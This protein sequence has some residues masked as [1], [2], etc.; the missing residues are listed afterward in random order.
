[1]A[2]MNCKWRK[3]A[4]RQSKERTI[5]DARWVR[6]RRGA[7]RLVTDAPNEVQYCERRREGFW[8]A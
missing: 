1:M 8:V 7:W 3:G 4:Q 6:G 5:D 2:K